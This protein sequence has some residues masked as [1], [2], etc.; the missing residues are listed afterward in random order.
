MRIGVIGAGRLGLSFA[1]VC[2]KNGIPVTISDKNEQYIKNLKNGFCTT[3]EPFILDLLSKKRFLEFANTNEEVIKS[4]DYIWTFVETPSNSDGTYDVTKLWDVVSD[5]KKAFENEIS[6]F[7]KTFIV[8]CTTNPGDVAKIQELLSQYSMNVVYNPEFVAQGEIV[9]NLQESKMVLLGALEGQDLK[10]IIN[11]YR[12]V[13]DSAVNFNIMSYT[14]AELTKISINCFLTTKISFANMI[15]E[16]A[17]KTGLREEVGNIL[18]AVGS[19]PR[20]NN[21]FLKYGFGFGGPC[22][23]R[24]NKALSV[25]AK[26]YNANAKL[27]DLVHEMNYD[28]TEFLVNYYSEMNPDKS[29]PFVMKHISYKRGTDI[30]TDSQQYNLCLSLLDKGY[31]VFVQEIDSVINQFKTKD[32]GDRLKFFRYGTNPKGYLIDL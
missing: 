26:K 13:C 12:A 3:N 8:G 25:H 5:F 4:C 28:H 15:G 18:K 32:M 23:P 30:L 27:S 21:K 19:D 17:I 7:G 20:I 24:D 11:L 10:I 16:I 22:L 14:A 2:D 6:V 31:T 9:N 29:V 1:L